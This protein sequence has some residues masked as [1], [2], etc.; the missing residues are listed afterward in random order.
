MRLFFL[1]GKLEFRGNRAMI[2]DGRNLTEINGQF[3]AKQI[4]RQSFSQ[5]WKA[6]ALTLRH[7]AEISFQSMLTLR[8]IYE[9][10]LAL[11][12]TLHTIHKMLSTRNCPI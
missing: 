9:N 4:Q 6:V 11:N 7:A 5:F 8:V 1:D 2:L 3:L 10:V 12:W